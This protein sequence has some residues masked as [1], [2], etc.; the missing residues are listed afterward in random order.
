M[1]N[2]NAKI[3]VLIRKIWNHLQ[4]KDKKESNYS[5][6]CGTIKWVTTTPV[7]NL[8]VSKS[9]N[10]YKKLSKGRI[11]NLWNQSNNNKILM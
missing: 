7:F 9:T 6:R 10:L 8:E 2:I 3:T 5:T 11:N 1:P 4:N